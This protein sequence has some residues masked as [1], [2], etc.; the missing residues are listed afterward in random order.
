[1]DGRTSLPAATRTEQPELP[2]SQLK[3]ELPAP[4]FESEL[5]SSQFKSELPASQFESELPTSQTEQPE[6][7]ASRSLSKVTPAK[8]SELPASY[9]AAG[10]T[11][12][13]KS[14]APTAPTRAQSVRV[15]GGGGKQRFGTPPTALRPRSLEFD[16]EKKSESEFG[17]NKSG[18][19]SQGASSMDAAENPFGFEK[20]YGRPRQHKRVQ[21][22]C[23]NAL[24]RTGCA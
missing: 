3:S 24:E 6:L 18:A 5:P 9:S 8:Q 4:H 14:V 16:T 1:M 21:H 7:P 17:F 15:L 23:C 2:A 20:R 22:I 13:T 11:P 19:A 12:G 10:V